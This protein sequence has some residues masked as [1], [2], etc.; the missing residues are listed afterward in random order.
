MNTLLAECIVV[1]ID[2]GEEHRLNEYNFHNHPEY[3][4]G[5]GWQYM[6]FIVNT[7]KPYIDAHFRTLPERE[8][9]HIAGSSMGGLV[10]LYGALH[11]AETFGTAGVFSP[12][13]WLVPDAT[14]EL[15]VIAAK[16]QDLPQ[17]FYFYGG[18]KESDDMLTHI[19]SMAGLLRKYPQYSVAIT[20]DPEGD[21]SEYRWGNMFPHYYEWLAEG[22]PGYT[23]SDV[24]A[25]QSA[26]E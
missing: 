5:E 11:F 2:N 15:E 4:P 7:L 18:A 9:T 19:H 24:R 3:G 1:G 12:S 21:H 16:K 25:E 13:L 17:R 6:G 20:I 10:S 22:M 26:A 8:Y 23:K 14:T